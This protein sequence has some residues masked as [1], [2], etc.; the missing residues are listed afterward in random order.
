MSSRQTFEV[1][2]KPAARQEKKIKIPARYEI[3][4]KVNKWG[5]D[6][7][8]PIA[9]RRNEKRDQL[10]N[11]AVF[12]IERDKNKKDLAVKQIEARFK[13]AKMLKVGMAKGQEFP[14]V[15]AEKIIDIFPML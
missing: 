15:V 2:E 5:V 9:V 6:I 14:G 1:E 13:Q 11:Q 3:I 12:T 10:D 8:N 4:D 7:R